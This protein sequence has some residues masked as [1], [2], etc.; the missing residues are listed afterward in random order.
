MQN[1][2]QM[3]ELARAIARARRAAVFTGAGISTDSGIPD[4]RIP[5]GI[6]TRMAPIDFSDFLASE[7]AR[8]ETWRRRALACRL[9]DGYRGSDNPISQPLLDGA[10]F[11]HI[12]DLDEIDPTTVIVATR[13]LGELH[14]RT[15]EVA[16][17]NRGLEVR[18]AEQVEEL[19]RVGRLKR[20]LAPQLAELIVTQG[21]EKILESHRRDIVVVFC[22]LRGYTAFTETAEPEEVLDFLRQY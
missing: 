13:L 12:P 9:R 22:D 7:E 3:A 10:R 18:V 8:R 5:G 14:Q 11:V 15:H 20:F 17:L 21:D 6:W 4:F 1:D 16:E 19:A 2:L